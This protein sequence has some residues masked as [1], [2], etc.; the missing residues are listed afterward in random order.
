MVDYSIT[1]RIDVVALSGDLVD[2]DNRFYEAIGP[3]E[4]GLR[5][6]HEA[7]ITTVAVAGNHDFGVLP[8]LARALPVGCFRML[9]A[10][11]GWERAT[12]TSSAGETLHVD[13]WSFDA[14]HVRKNPLAS[15]DLPVASEPVLGLLHAD[16]DQPTSPYAPVT[17]SDLQARHV[18]MWLLGHIH[19]PTLR[20]ATGHP[21]VLYPGSPQP[22]DPGERSA[23]GAWIVEFTAGGPPIPLFVSLANVRYET[24]EVDVT[25]V[26]DVSAARVLLIDAIR[27]HAERC[28][29]EGDA[30]RH[31]SIRVRLVGRT[32][33]H[34]AIS[35]D[36]E[37]APDMDFSVG[38][39][40]IYVERVTSDARALRDIAALAEGSDAVAWVARVLRD[41]D[42]GGEPG[43]DHADLIRLAAGSLSTVKAAK[44]YRSLDMVSTEEDPA[45]LHAYLAAAAAALLDE[46]LEQSEAAR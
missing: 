30:L 35:S 28:A 20:T 37:Q 45:A 11:G 44:P 25:D 9:G 40:A 5:R 38:D 34:R 16:L 21:P 12:I 15:Y 32:S 10:G 43:P 6:L 42:R 17:L 39:V 29:A 46:L 41:F 14:P 26:T 4:R 19:A 31:L 3:L 1:N 22:L 8:D 7:G 18:S 2:R 33:A 23:H 24:V 36:M 13:G 27:A